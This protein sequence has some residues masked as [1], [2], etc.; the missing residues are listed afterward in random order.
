MTEYPTTPMTEYPA[1]AMKDVLF[2]LHSALTRI[3]TMDEGADLQGRTVEELF[4]N[5]I[6]WHPEP[7]VANWAKHEIHRLFVDFPAEKGG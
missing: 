1:T 7:I 4:I 2:A 6:K 5:A 3:V